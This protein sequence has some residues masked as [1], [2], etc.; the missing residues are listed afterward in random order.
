MADAITNVK[1]QKEPKEQKLQKIEGKRKAAAVMVAIGTDH[2]AKIYKNLKDDEIETLTLEV[3]TLPKLDNENMDAVLNEFYEMCLA[4][5]FIVEGGVDYAKDVLEKAF[6]VQNARNVIDKVIISLGNKSF[7][8]MKKVDPKQLFSFIQNEHPQTIALI[9]SHATKLQASSVLGML[10]KEKQVEVI[11]RIAKMDRTSPDI[12]KEVETALQKK[13][14]TLGVAEVTDLGG[15]KYTAE[16]LNSVD[17]GTEKYIFDTLGKRDIELADEIRKLM[18]VF[19]DI[20]SLDDMAMQ[21]LNRELDPKDIVIALKTAT[22]E[23]KNTFFRNMS[24]RVVDQVKEDIEYLR[25]IRHRDIEAA[26]QRIVSKIRDLEEMGEIVV[27]HGKD[28]EFV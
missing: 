9:L 24:K 6:G 3:A 11:E 5:K 28:D 2:A 23:V 10:S 26:Q 13:L 1:E 21:R 17:R 7:D 22:E 18:F 14:S 15:V 25:N 20:V 19:E 4:Q 16:L 27:S 8:F 12:I